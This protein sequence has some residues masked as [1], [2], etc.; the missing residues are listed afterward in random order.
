ME[1]KNI[2]ITGG[3]GYIGSHTA[4]VLLE[5]GY[6][7]TIV[8]NLVNSSEES[9]RRIRTIMNIPATEDS[10]IR[11][12]N[13][14]ICD[15][16]AFEVVFKSS[17]TFYACIHFAGLKAVGESVEKPL[18]YY[19]N[20]ITGTLVLLKLMDKYNCTNIVF[21]SSATVYGMAKSPITEDTPVGSGITNAYGR[22]K[23]MIEEIIHDFITSKV[24]LQKKQANNNI[25]SKKWTGTILRYFNPVGAHNSGL[26]GEDPYGVPNNLMPFIAQVAVGRR[27]KLTVFG[28]DYNTKDGTGVR[29]Y[30]HVMDLAEGHVAA[31]KY[32]EKV[33]GDYKMTDLT[34]TELIDNTTENITEES[35]KTGFDVFNLGAGNGV[36]V[37]EMINA[38]EKASGQKIPY[39]IGDRRAGDI[40]ICYANVDKASRFLNWKSKRSLHDMC[41]DL[42]RWQNMNPLGYNVTNN[43]K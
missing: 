24:M 23:F 34:S 37:L 31:V 18:M 38:M 25:K 16:N 11:Y 40:D 13:A 27:E 3:T 7:V 35:K 2:L 21:S 39:T 32:V 17:P 10:R 12:F 8:D 30:V 41:S 14:N 9:L 19:E 1:R 26:I 33:C 28:N 15:V 29:D 5:A 42:W 4:L 22:T 6:N 43:S 36:S 20:N